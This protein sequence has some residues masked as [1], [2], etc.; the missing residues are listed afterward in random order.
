LQAEYEVEVDWRGFELR[1][2][3]PKGGRRID[4]LFP[5]RAQ[6]LKA[7]V[8]QFGRGFGVN[9]VVPE[10]MNNTRRA[11]AVAEWARTQGK[12]VAFRDAAMEAYWRHAANIEDPEVLARLAEQA[13]L[14]GEGAKAAMDAP[15]YLARVDALRTEANTAG[16]SGIPTLFVGSYRIVGCQPYEVY[17]EAVRRVGGKP[18]A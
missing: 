2:D 14:P 18:R 17:A 9:I 5:G 11:L 13:G 6:S 10:R 3:T 8:E 12:L 4:E 1:P 7:H 16:V 15:E